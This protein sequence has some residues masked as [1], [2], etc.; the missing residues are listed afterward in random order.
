MAHNIC[1]IDNDF[2]TKF[3]EVEEY[4]F[5]DTIVLNSTDIRI[6]YNKVKDWKNGN[7]V[8]SLVE[9]L[10]NDRKTNWKICG[11]KAPEIFL[12]HIAEDSYNPDMIVFDWDYD[13]KRGEG[14]DI[15]SLLYEILELKYCIIKIYSGADKDKEINEVLEQDRFKSHTNR[16]SFLSKKVKDSTATLVENL[17]E[18]YNVNFSHGFKN[19]FLKE[20]DIAINRVLSN[21]GE[22]SYNEFISTFGYHDKKNNKAILNGAEFVEIIAEKTKSNLVS[23]GE[24]NDEFIVDY[25]EIDNDVSIRK[26]WFNRMFHFPMDNIVRKGDIINLNGEELKYLVISSDCHLSGFW[27]KNLGYLS[28]VPIYPLTNPNLKLILK[29]NSELGK[30]KITSLTNPQLI[31]S[32][33]VLPGIFYE[34]DS[35]EDGV[36]ITKEI[37]S[38]KIELNGNSPT[39]VLEY[40]DSEELNGT[41]RAKLNEP[42]LTPLVDFIISNITDLGVPDYPDSVKE[43]FKN[44]IRQLN[45]E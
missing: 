11:F 17:Q 28:L 30:F 4:A 41:N 1:I 38:F 16:I 9:G 12:N 8:R 6:L 18:R 34:E 43:L 29:Q 27:K 19:T 13:G 39:K 14:D 22:L 23:S 15:V 33:T 44:Q 3:D 31:S 2:P 37:R 7:P 26:L 24:F 5:D 36:L 35:F 32:I 21:I 45:N 40:T 42:F 20:M 25:Q 10:L